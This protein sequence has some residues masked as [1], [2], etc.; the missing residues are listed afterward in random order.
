MKYKLVSLLLLA[1]F[2]ISCSSFSMD[3]NAKRLIDNFYYNLKSDNPNANIQYF[4]DDYYSVT[5]REET[6]KLFDIL[7]E[8]VGN[9]QNYELTY[10]M[11]TRSTGGTKGKA[12][13]IIRATYTVHW[14]DGTTTDSFLLFLPSGS[15]IY[16]IDGYH[17][18]IKL[19]LK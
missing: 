12:G 19:D 10:Q 13:K 14:S 3:E 2:I 11:V 1:F 7:K 17:T 6:L 18:E 8:K 9:M 4:S 5:T 16:K 15:S